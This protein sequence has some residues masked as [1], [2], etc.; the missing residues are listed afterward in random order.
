MD[1]QRCP[2]LK[3]VMDWLGQLRIDLQGMVHWLNAKFLLVNILEMMSD[4]DF[5]WFIFIAGE[6]DFA[7]DI[8]HTRLFLFPANHV[9]QG[10]GGGMND[11]TS[12]LV[13]KRIFLAVA[14]KFDRAIVPQRKLVIFFLLDDY[15][16]FFRHLACSRL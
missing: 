9:Y 10:F 8:N 6:C 5:Y 11:F 7:F 14:V 15:F 2:K 13:L 12:E 3:R 16:P 1:I 4:I